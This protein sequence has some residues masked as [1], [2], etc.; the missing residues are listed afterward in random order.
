[1][2][3]DVQFILVIGTHNP[4]LT[5]FK[6]A[7]ESARGLFDY[8]IIVDDG[9]TVPIDEFLKNFDKRGLNGDFYQHAKNEK[10]FQARNTANN[11]ITDTFP[12]FNGW[13]I[14][15][16]DDDLLIRENVEKLKEIALE[17]DADILHF[18]IELFGE[19]TGRWATHPNMDAILDNNQIPSGSWYRYH[20]YTALNGFQLAEG[21]DWDF[22]ARAKKNGFKFKFFEEPVYKHRMRKGS[23]SSDWVGDRFNTIRNNVRKN[24]E[25]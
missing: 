1:M 3:Q 4:N 10:F 14:T 9:S 11:V 17:T 21:E 25:K 23:M 5:W 8:I 15:L 18:P 22:W 19:Q 24:Y 12:H 20:V 13:V 2:E 6:D 16:D 7:L